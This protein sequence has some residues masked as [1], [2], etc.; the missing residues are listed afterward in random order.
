MQPIND[1]DRPGVPIVDHRRGDANGDRKGKLSKATI[2]FMAGRDYKV[3]D[4][5]QPV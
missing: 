3:I 5:S 1:V 2:D 4:R